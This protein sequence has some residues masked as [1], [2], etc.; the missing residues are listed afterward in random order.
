MAVLN[1][2]VASGVRCLLLGAVLLPLALAWTS[3]EDAAIA[4]CT[5][6]RSRYPHLVAFPGEITSFDVSD[7]SQC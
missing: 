7:P 5:T 3:S 6:L 2:V 1:S 4:A